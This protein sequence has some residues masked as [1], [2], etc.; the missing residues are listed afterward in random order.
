MRVHKIEYWGGEAPH[1]NPEIYG[2]F[3]LR[4]D[5]MC[6]RKLHKAQERP[7]SAQLSQRVRNSVCFHQ[8]I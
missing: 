5:C 1:G 4:I 3:S 2:G 6:V 7:I 8:S